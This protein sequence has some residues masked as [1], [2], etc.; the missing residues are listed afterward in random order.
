MTAP[1]Q[2]YHAPRWWGN[3]EWLGISNNP[4]NYNNNGDVPGT[5]QH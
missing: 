4:R 3:G 1:T 2:Q 5:H